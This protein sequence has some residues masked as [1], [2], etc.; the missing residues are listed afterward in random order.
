MAVGHAFQHVPEVGERLDA[1]ELCGGEQGR[2]GGPAFGA[3][4]RSREQVV[5]AAE[6]Y[7]PFIL[8]MSGRN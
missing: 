4:I 6:R 2:D 8:P 3:A 1:V 7:C 5:L